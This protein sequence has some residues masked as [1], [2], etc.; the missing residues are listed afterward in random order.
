MKIYLYN[1]GFIKR[2]A[3]LFQNGVILGKKF[4]SYES[5]VPYILQFFIDYNL[6]GMSF[7]HVPNQYT[8]QRRKSNSSNNIDF[9][10]S[11]ENLIEP[12]SV[13]ESEIDIVA[14]YIL[15]RITCDTTPS[16]QHQNPGISAIWKDEQYRRD[17]I[18]DLDSNV[19]HRFILIR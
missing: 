7:L 19:F 11:L 16:S 14:Q 15:N 2:A 13:S 1:P 8:K 17:K 6:Y 10:D 18:I 9:K 3:S 4:Q 12:I 5:H